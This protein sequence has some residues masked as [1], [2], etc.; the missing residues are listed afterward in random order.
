MTSLRPSF[1]TEH[2]SVS[3]LDSKAHI[4]ETGDEAPKLSDELNIIPCFPNW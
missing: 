1:I 3:S 2:H 4:V